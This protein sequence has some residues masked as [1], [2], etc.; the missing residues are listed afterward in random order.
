MPTFL[1][2]VFRSKDAGGSKKNAQQAEASAAPTKPRWEDAWQRNEVQPEEVQ[3]LLKGCT[4]E[5]KSRGGFSHLFI[6]FRVL[7]LRLIRTH[8]YYRSLAIALPLGICD[9]LSVRTR[10]VEHAS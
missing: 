8:A 7:V 1:S 10:L 4:Q 5:I 9:G 2:K 6:Y 3:E